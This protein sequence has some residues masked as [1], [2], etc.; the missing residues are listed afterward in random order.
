MAN[1]RA[2][3][4]SG[5]PLRSS[6]WFRGAVFGL[7]TLLATW[8]LL[9]IG[10][11]IGASVVRVAADPEA[12]NGGG[13]DTVRVLALGD[14]W[15]AGSEAPPGQGFVDEVERGLADALGPHE[16]EVRNLGL[17]G[18]NTAHVAL[19]ALDE[20]KS[21]QPDLI[22]VLVGVNNGTSFARVS[23]FDH[24]T[25]TVGASGPWF[26][27]LRTVKAA[28]LLFAGVRGSAWEE[29]MPTDI[30]ARGWPASTVPA[31]PAFLSAA[32]NGYYHRRT[33]AEPPPTGS[34]LADKAWVLL[35][36]AQQRD[37]IRADELAKELT[38]AHGWNEESRHPPRARYFEE[39]LGRYALLRFARETEDWRAVRRHGGAL[40][41]VPSRTVLTDAGAAE[42]ALLAGNWRLAGGY[43]EAA[44]QKGPGFPDLLDLASR[45]PPPA[46]TGFIEGILE[47]SPPRR[48][49]A[50]DRARQIDGWRHPEEAA[51]HRAEWL[52]R[53]PDD[54][55]VLSELAL[56][57]L[58]HEGWTRSDRLMGLVEDWDKT[59]L[60]AP[61]S[62]DPADW[63]YYL[64]RAGEA[65]G[66]DRVQK[67]LAWSLE[68]FPD[69]PGVLYA[70]AR[71]YV[72]TGECVKAVNVA[73][74]HYLRRGDPQRYLDAVGD[75]LTHSDAMKHLDRMVG[76]WGALETRGRWSDAFGQSRDPGV[77]FRRHMDTLA[78]AAAAQ[79]AVVLMLDYPNPRHEYE[80]F[81]AQ[82]RGY[83]AS[84]DMPFLDLYGAFSEDFTPEEWDQLIASGGHCNAEGYREMG[85]RI[86][87]RLTEDPIFVSALQPARG[88]TP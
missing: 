65:G 80:E 33:A 71:V 74:E 64:H 47:E 53:H 8:I 3:T 7:W 77:L 35:Y 14:S 27:R 82:F 78:T 40:H 15:V 45:F 61:T 24:R 81:R 29:V 34:L 42:A 5:F 17:P 41:D 36:A 13:G 67:A 66:A 9:E 31:A 38:Q 43:L 85:V 72:S 88:S 46:R 37:L 22:M 79:G 62:T 20:L 59:G 58:G 69:D 23:E 25:G 4:V 55:V 44:W 73:K 1:G 76:D 21:F 52:R 30:A 87:E 18:A 54:R 6:P 50:L 57:I 12:V 86:L 26:D 49:S 63:R 2:G 56:W 60:P 28:R 39:I 16:V 10:L 70:A 75:C 48:A 83:A 11:R 32:G 84:R 68:A 51:P 19:T